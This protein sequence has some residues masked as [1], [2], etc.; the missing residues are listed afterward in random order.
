MT[1][2]LLTSI[3]GPTTGLQAAGQLRE[4]IAHHRARAAFPPTLF[5]H[6]R[7]THRD[8]IL[9]TYG[10]QVREPGKPPLQSLAALC[11]N[12]LL[13][14]SNAS[15][16]TPHAQR[17][18]LITGIH[19]LPFYPYSSD[20]G[21]SVIDYRQVDPALGSWA[22]IERIGQRFGLMFDAVINHISA[23]SAWFQQF[24]QDD[25]HYREY[26]I[27]VS[28][29]PDLSQV[30]RPRT[31]P[32]LTHFDT[33]SGEKAV[34]TTF[35]PD[36]VDLNYANPA[37]L[38]EIIDLILFYAAKGAEVI[39]LD[40]IAYLW[41][42]AGTT[43][44]HLPQTHQVIQLLRAVLDEVAPHVLLITETNVPHADNISYFGSGE[45]EAQ[46]VYNFALPPLVLHTLQTGSAQ[47]LSRWA[48]SLVLPMSSTTFFNF[49]ASHDGIGVNPVRGIL[50]DDEIEHMIQVVQQH[51]GL[52]S[53]K[54]NSDGSQSPY[55]LNISYFDALSDP[56]STE[57]ESLQ[58]QRF[59][60]AHAIQ[61]ALTGVPGIYFHSL[62]GS[63]SW[64]AGVAHSGRSRSINRQKLDLD[65]LERELQ[66][67]ASLRS[68]VFA[69]LAAL[70]QIRAGQAAFDPYG[71][72]QVV[73]A[74]PGIFALWRTTPSGDQR[75]L[76]LQ[77]VTDTVQ[78]VPAGLMPTPALE[79]VSSQPIDRTTGQSFILQ[80]YQT[81]WLLESG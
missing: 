73:E 42:Q 26:F 32:L 11:E 49:L 9:I 58:V 34:W 46:L 70:L 25:P 22:D 39:R 10:D 2:N 67:R 75:I 74:G 13:A 5:F 53:Y 28:G 77:N 30:V 3:Y 1:Q 47:A 43:C 68:Q 27:V 51:Q 45:N 33:P 65:S 56:A 48:A 36:Q 44:I 54:N 71:Q 14:P 37:V 41:K 64:Q 66:D 59:L 35:S 38:L 31:L 17:Q 16:S 50:S 6:G 57:P 24:L 21:F 29:N 18:P 78:T 76:C 40:A 72:Q 8:A 81:A 12:T 61:L 19:L 63:R 15:S 79:L 20:D 69:G 62:F 52:V 55:E 23:H 60:A 4:I 80:P 7:F